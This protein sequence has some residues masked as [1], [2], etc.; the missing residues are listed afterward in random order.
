[1][2]SGC[3]FVRAIRRILEPIREFSESY[4]DDMAVHSMT[5]PLHLRHIDEYLSTIRASGIT[6]NLDKCEFGKPVVRYIGH[7]I[8]SG[9]R[10][11]DPLKVEAIMKLK[12]PET[13]KQVRQIM[14]LFSHFRD[15]IG[16]FSEISK[17]ISDLT[18]KNI[19]TRVPW[20]KEQE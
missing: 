13:K 5:W 20:G 17:P 12:A 8:G 2:S 15:Y 10:S 7:L 16:S 19:P 6:L 3:T 18:C 4:V 14:G 11:P 1:M 9:Q